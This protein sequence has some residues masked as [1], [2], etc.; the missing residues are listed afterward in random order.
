MSF[1]TIFY[2]KRKYCEKSQ[3]NRHKQFVNWFLLG[4][5]KNQ[6]LS[7]IIIFILDH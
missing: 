7:F 6:Y 3:R 4:F 5:H 1:N 2:N